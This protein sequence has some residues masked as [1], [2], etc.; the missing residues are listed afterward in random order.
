M[1]N[2]PTS[3]HRFL[4]AGLCILTWLLCLLGCSQ[5]PAD[6]ANGGADDLATE[7]DSA[8]DLESDPGDPV[9][10][11]EDP[12][13]LPDGQLD[14]ADGQPVDLV[15][16][17][18]GDAPVADQPMDQGADTLD[19]PDLDRTMW[20]AAQ[21]PYATSTAVSVPTEPLYVQLRVEGVT[22]FEAADPSLA[23][24]VGW[25]P[26]GTLPDQ[27][28]WR[29]SSAE[30][31]PSCAYCGENEEYMGSVAPDQE[32]VFLWAGRISYAGNGPLYCDRAD[33]GRAGSEDGWSVDDA[34]RIVVVDEGEISVISL[35]L[36]CLQDDWDRR[37]PIIA[38]TLAALRPDLMGFQEVCAEP[39]GRDNLVE[40][41]DGLSQRTGAVYRVERTVTHRSWDRYD[42]GLAL[43][44][45]HTV[46]EFAAEA[47]PA[48]IFPRKVILW[49]ASTPQGGVLFATTHLDYQSGEVRGEQIAVVVSELEERRRVGEPV[50]LTGD[51][52]ESPGGAVQQALDAA[53]YTDLWDA[54][55]SSESG[56]TYPADDPSARIDYIWLNPGESG[57]EPGSI[58]RILDTPVAGVY[59]SDH[60]GLYATTS[61]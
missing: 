52:N 38:D 16:D 4:R 59:G 54:L 39:G 14:Q 24:E 33:G 36:R 42:E 37:L 9:D 27:P 6:A 17:P 30:F 44:S 35:N 43:V 50:I 18:T 28:A 8:R 32:G 60:L 57:W 53:G 2:K 49:R 31:N 19:R 13:G 7:D 25:G 29:W 1:A 5:E 40:L 3:D 34:G 21:W 46:G 56:P 55:R 41:V 10:S 12:A 22:P 45:P 51:L 20:C 15:G 23:V 11:R 61:R 47:L 58:D 26:L 48:G